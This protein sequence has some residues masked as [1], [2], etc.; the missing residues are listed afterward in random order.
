MKILIA[1]DYCPQE[2]VSFLLEKGCYHTIFGEV[3]DVISLSDFSV[4]NFETCIATNTD[5]PISKYGPN[6]KCTEKVVEALK[7]AGFNCITLA[8]NHF[9]D[10]GEEAVGRTIKKI[11]E[12]NLRTVGGG[13]EQTS[14]ILYVDIKD[15]KVAFINAC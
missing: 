13:K 8:N 4:V 7:W 9:R 14:Q 12:N 2:R 11:Q 6:L 15:K 5:A 10:Y 1:G 3:K